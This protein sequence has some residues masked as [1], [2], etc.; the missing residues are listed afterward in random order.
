MY[1]V[2]IA[3]S[4]STKKSIQLVYPS[5]QLLESPQ[6]IVF[7][8]FN[9]DDYES[10]ANGVLS[11]TK[12]VIL[13]PASDGVRQITRVINKYPQISSIH[14]V[15]HG[16][17]GYLCLGNSELSINSIKNDQTQT[18]ELKTWSVSNILLYGCN[19]AAGDSGAE[20]IEKLHQ[21]TGANIAA[22][23]RP[24]GNVALGGDWELEV[25]R[26]ELE[27]DIP[28]THETQQQWDYVLEND[29][30]EERPAVFHI[31]D[32]VLKEFNPLTG[33]WSQR[34]DTQKKIN[35]AG[36]SRDTNGNNYIY[37]IEDSGTGS[38]HRLVRISS[39]GIVKY[40]KSDGSLSDSSVDAFTING[41]IDDN[42][43]TFDSRPAAGDMD[44]VG[45][46]WVIL[47]EV[48]TG[49]IQSG[50]AT[51]RSSL[52]RINITNPSH[53]S[54]GKIDVNWGWATFNEVPED[55]VYHPS[56]K[57]L[58][59]VGHMGRIL[60]IDTT[61]AVLFNNSNTNADKI[62]SRLAS[63]TPLRSNTGGTATN[64][65][66]T[67]DLTG[68]VTSPSFDQLGFEVA[69]SGSEEG[70]YISTRDTAYNITSFNETGILNNSQRAEELFNNSAE[71]QTEEKTDGIS[72]SHLKSVFQIPLI[73]LDGIDT[74]PQNHAVT[75]TENT[76]LVKIVDTDSI[77]GLIIKDYLNNN[78][79][80]PAVG[81]VNNTG[82][83]AKENRLKTAIITLTNPKNGDQL[84]VNG[85][86]L[87]NP[88][89][90]E[91]DITATLAETPTDITITLTTT[92][93][94][95]ANLF[96]A[97]I[98]NIDFNNTSESPDTTPREITFELIDE[99]NNSSKEIFV[100]NS[101]DV[102]TTIVTV[103]A[104][105]DA[106]VLDNTKN[107]AGATAPIQLTV[108]EDTTATGTVGNLVSEMIALNQNVTDVD[109]SPLTGIAITDIDET[110]GTWHYST[111]GGTSWTAVG[112]VSETSA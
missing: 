53:S 56:S 13:D 66:G 112:T 30:F 48:E 27:V 108:D 9:V 37:G 19:V 31:N 81:N 91:T 100:T 34:F 95:S 3:Q 84:L 87:T 89:T 40:I 75:F 44:D 107:A 102:H 25:V 39:D 33:V 104:V 50:N 4:V 94:V 65:I 47:K 52:L 46:L 7:I 24:T 79:T 6:Q 2:S 90:I 93:P 42:T 16:A 86:L 55:I 43:V 38:D 32:G 83:I 72:T 8:D 17:P 61:S 106:P 60:R 68:M 14:I 63:N 76:G 36:L 67:S 82:V 62:D 5:N 26:G 35:A 11:G 23:A 99:D 110:N 74:D 15:S 73:D 1:Q 85:A 57:H 22:S 41:T 59:G 92:T 10:L 58:Y 51:N 18:L 49:P 28:F 77:N 103:D 29:P 105:N 64:N 21:L 111:D 12:V 88:T 98:K 70:L 54:T 69:W 20:F 109:A 71:G 78:G 101:N 96:V 97:A 80:S 45:N